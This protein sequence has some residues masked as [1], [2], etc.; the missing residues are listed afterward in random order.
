MAILE[1]WRGF[2]NCR[3]RVLCLTA[4]CCIC[5]GIEFVQLVPTKT[6]GCCVYP[7]Q[8]PETASVPD[9]RT[10]LCCAPPSCFEQFEVA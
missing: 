4:V 9:G 10:Q 2:G 7:E 5:S 3:S 8:Q 6:R 1:V